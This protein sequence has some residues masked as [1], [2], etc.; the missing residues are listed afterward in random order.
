[1]HG[2]Q[3]NLQGDPGT[4]KIMTKIG[5]IIKGRP[6]IA[7][8]YQIGSVCYCDCTII[9]DLVVPLHMQLTIIV[10]VIITHSLINFQPAIL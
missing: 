8:A 4:N 6:V 3:S 5:K 7:A 2:M 10:F 9:Y 1:M